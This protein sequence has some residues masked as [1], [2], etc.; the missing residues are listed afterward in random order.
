[1][2]QVKSLAQFSLQDDRAR[3]K[4]RVFQAL[5]P[6]ERNIEKGI[7]KICPFGFVPAS[8]RRMVGIRRGDYKRISVG[9]AR[10][11]NARIASRNDHDLVAHARSV[12]HVGE[13]GGRQR[14]S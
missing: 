7:A 11:E 1:V 6:T 2:R 4:E 8:E 10:Y 14:F 5:G 3:K 12:E 9:E 13:I